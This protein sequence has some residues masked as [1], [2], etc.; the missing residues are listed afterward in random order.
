MSDVWS[1]LITGPATYPDPW[2]AAAGEAG[3]EALSWPLLTCVEGPA[4]IAP[5]ARPDW[6]AITSSSRW[7]PIRSSTLR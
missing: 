1:V 2:L 5:D 6:I 3:W 4:T 7:A